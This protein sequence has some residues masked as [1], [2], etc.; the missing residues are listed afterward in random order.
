MARS[1]LKKVESLQEGKVLPRLHRIAAERQM[2]DL[3]QAEALYR[4]AVETT[5]DLET[6]LFFLKKFATFAAKVCVCVC[7]CRPAMRLPVF[8]SCMVLAVL[9]SLAQFL[10]DLG[11]MRTLMREAL[12]HNAVSWVV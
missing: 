10:K 5:E 8:V 3:K 7:V 4:D 12:S 2:G 11:M 6:K 1:I 9:L